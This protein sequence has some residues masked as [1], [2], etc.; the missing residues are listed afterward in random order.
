VAGLL[1]GLVALPGVASAQPAPSDQGVLSLTP[2]RRNIVAKPPLTLSPATVRNTTQLTMRVRVFPTLLFQHLDGTFGF[3]ETPRELNAARLIFPVEPRRFTLEP[4]EARVLRLR[5]ALLPR[6]AKAAYVGLLV[7]GVPRSRAGGGVGSILRLLGVNFFRRPGRFRT[8]GELVRV[9]GEQAE[10]RVLRFKPRVRNTGEIHAQPRRGRCVIRDAQGEERFRARFGDGVVLPRNQREY[11]F[12][13]RRPVLPAG[14]YRVDCAM[15][16]GRTPDRVTQRLRLSG[17]NT[18]PTAELKLDAL[19]GAGEIGGPAEATIRF[20]NAGSKATAAFVNLS[21]A[22]LGQGNPRIVARKRLPQG[23]LEAGAR[24]T[25]DAELGELTTG[26]NWRITAELTDGRDRFG[27]LTA[28]FVPVKE[29]GLGERILDALRDLLWLWIL[30]VLAAILYVLWRLRRDRRR[31]E[32]ELER[33][34]AAA[35]PAV[36]RAPAPAASATPAVPRPATP[37]APVPAAA[38]GR[39]NINTASVEELMTLPGVG[40]RAAERII[41]RRE[42]HGPFGSL[43]DLGEIQGFHAERIRRLRENADV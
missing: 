15:R 40:R 43:E 37:A 3:N 33:A 34:S 41:E 28:D 12:L 10:P 29:K 16:F 31:L 23:T 42:A 14:S 17:P 9:T 18:L 13:L 20:R 5:W 24:R 21:L 32:E 38:P 4:G 6:G 35:T 1:T 8:A 7:E 11:P 26:G 36:P 22:R 19:N 39:V 27:S 25:L 2:P 30:L